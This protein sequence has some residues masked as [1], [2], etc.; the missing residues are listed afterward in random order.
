[1]RKMRQSL[2]ATGIFAVLSLPVFGQISLGGL[3][4]VARDS[5]SGKPLAEAQ[6]VAHEMRKDTRSTA[7]STTNGAF[8]IALEPGWYED[9]HQEWPSKSYIEDTLGF[10]RNSRARTPLGV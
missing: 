2:L 3:S 7:V 4:G 9:G 5:A 6:I 10:R 8:V 1:M